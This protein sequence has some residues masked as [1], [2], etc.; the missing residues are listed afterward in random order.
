MTSMPGDEEEESD[1]IAHQFNLRP[2]MVV[3]I[4]LPAD[5]TEKEAERFSGFVR[6]LPL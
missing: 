5:F 2:G 3:S 4:E 6:S 1:L